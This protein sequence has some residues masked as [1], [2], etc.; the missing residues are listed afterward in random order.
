M[1]D[2]AKLVLKHDGVIWG[3]YVWSKFIDYKPTRINARFVSVN[4]FVDA[5]C[6]RAFLIDINERFEIVKIKH[7]DIILKDPETD[8]ELIL[9]IFVNNPVAEIAFHDN[10]DFT[11]NL[12]DYSRAGYSLRKIPAC[13]TL[14]AS[15]YDAVVQHIQSKTLKIVH[16]ESAMK[17][18]PR[19]LKLGWLMIE[20]SLHIYTGKTHTT[21]CAICSNQMGEDDTCLHT[22]CGH[23]FHL[24]CIKPWYSKSP[25]CPLCREHI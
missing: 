18:A 23:V 4:V 24:E 20:N 11:C 3:E 6:P 17:N 10:V 14:E 16:V 25:T 21:D 5:S 15:P 9:E 1:D 7:N 8:E 19:M 13:L 12:I 22:A 2:L